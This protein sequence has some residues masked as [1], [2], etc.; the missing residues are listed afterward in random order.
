MY[1]G[2]TIRKPTSRKRWIIFTGCVN[3]I[4]TENLEK[5]N[6]FKNSINQNAIHIYYTLY[7]I[8]CCHTLDYYLL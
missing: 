5:Y 4:E 8:H 1:F 3:I 6:S 2:A 7:V